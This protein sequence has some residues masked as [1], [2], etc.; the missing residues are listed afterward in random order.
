M[1]AGSFIHKAISAQPTVELPSF[2]IILISFLIVCFYL[3]PNR[4]NA[5]IY[6][7]LGED[8][9]KDH[10]AKVVIELLHLDLIEV[11]DAE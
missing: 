3:L 2:R 6:L 7:I 11:M 1:L 5:E 9:I 4:I 8:I 10:K